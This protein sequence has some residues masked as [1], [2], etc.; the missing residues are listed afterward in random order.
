MYPSYRPKTS[1][2]GYG[3]TADKSTAEPEG[4]ETEVYP[5]GDDKQ[6]S[7]DRQQ[8]SRAGRRTRKRA[9]TRK[10]ERT[11]DDYE[12]PSGHPAACWRQR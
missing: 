12:G 10:R 2:A 3:E 1:W 9:T 11:R 4:R 7:E 6:V 5:T 8:G